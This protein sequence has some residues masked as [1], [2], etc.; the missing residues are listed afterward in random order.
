MTSILN[1]RKYKL[2]FSQSPH[3]SNQLLIVGVSYIG[4][5]VDPVQLKLS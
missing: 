5:H 3:L 1:I 2:T 4:I